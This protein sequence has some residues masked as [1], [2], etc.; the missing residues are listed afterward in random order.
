MK[1][2]LITLITFISFSLS[3]QTSSIAYSYD[4]AGNR[5]QRSVLVFSGLAQQ[6]NDGQNDAAL[7]EHLAFEK[8]EVVFNLFPNPTVADFV[9]DVKY[10]KV[11]QQ[12]LNYSLY[13]V[14]G[15]V[16]ESKQSGELHHNFSLQNQPL[17]VYYLRIMSSN[18][19]FVKEIKI[20][21]K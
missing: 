6:N 11:E 9:V 19:E 12:A 18:G 13:D 2:L 14:S 17:G 16:I 5:I 10:N 15:K 8:G 21:K 20:L 7:Q 4:A 1:K 3:A